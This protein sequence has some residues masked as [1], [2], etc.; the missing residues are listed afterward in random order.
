MRPFD[1]LAPPLL[2]CGFLALA[3]LPLGRP[4]LAAAAPPPPERPAEAP[5]PVPEVQRAIE[6]FAR[7]EQ[8][9]PESDAHLRKLA[10]WQKKRFDE[11][12]RQ[13]IYYH[14]VHVGSK[15]GATMEQRFA[16]PLIIKLLA[17]RS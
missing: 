17:P 9:T 13:L 8:G 6:G 10:E 15:R 1:H 3:C 11:L 7:A 2:A 5:K 16:A 14:H 12:I 4:P